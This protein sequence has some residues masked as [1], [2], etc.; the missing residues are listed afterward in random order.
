M[1]KNVVISIENKVRELDG[2][3]WLGLNFVERGY[4]VTLGPSWEIIPT[5][6]VSKPDAYIAK[7]FGDGRVGFFSDLQDAGTVVCAISPE[8]GV[9]SSS[10][11]NYLNY[12]G[13]ALDMVDAYFSWGKTITEAFQSRYPEHKDGVYATGNPR[14]D[15]L[16]ETLRD[17]YSNKEKTEMYEDYIQINTSFSWGNPFDREMRRSKVQEMSH[18][19]ETDIDAKEQFYSRLFHLFI[20]LIVYLNGNISQDII[21]R[22]HPGENFN[23]YEEMVGHLENVHI[24]PYDDPRSWIY[25]SNGVIHFDCTTGIESALMEKP[26]L[27]YQPISDSTRDAGDILSQVVSDTATSREEVTKWIKTF[28]VPGNKHELKDAQRKQIMGFFPNINEI[29]APKICDIVDSMVADAPGFSGYKAPIKKKLAMR[30][31]KST[32]GTEI[33]NIYDNIH[34]LKHKLNNVDQSR[35]L[36]RKKQRQ[37]FPGLERSELRDKVQRF[38]PKINVSSVKIESL[39]RTR[40]CYTIRSASD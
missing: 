7:D 5:I 34:Y 20:E 1:N 13:K 32:F 30:A 15:L 19:L 6:D 18:R 17:V 29:A 24:E 9:N 33:I 35:G 14:F 31:K 2:R 27:S 10:Y 3:L 22:P 38:L 12:R 39:P 4:N 25:E 36:Q 37:K 23:T 8:C 16:T 26:V 21:V 40:Y 11:E 28:A